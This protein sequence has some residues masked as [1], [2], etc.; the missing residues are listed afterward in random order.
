MEYQALRR[1]VLYYP[2]V[3]RCTALRRDMTTVSRRYMS[4]KGGGRDEKG[5]CSEDKDT[6][7]EL[8]RVPSKIKRAYNGGKVAEG[9]GSH[10][11]SA[12]QQMN[13]SVDNVGTS[14]P[15]MFGSNLHLLV[16]KVASTEYIPIKEV[17]T[18]GLFAGY[19]PLFLGNSSFS[20]DMRKGKN[21]HALD[22]GLPNIQVIDASEKDGKLD[23]QEIIED[24]QKT[25]LIENV[26]DKEQ[27]SSSHKRKPVI[28]WDASISGMVYNDM[29]FKYVPK[30]VISKMKPFK[31]MRIERKS[32][33]KNSK[34]PSM[35]KLQFHNQRINDTQEL[36]NFYQNKTRLHESF[37]SS[38]S[39]QEFKYSSTNMSK[40]QKM[41]K[42]RGDFEH[43]LK[44]Y[45][46]KHTFIKNDQELFR[47]ELTKLNKI[48]SREF[49]KLTKLSI[50]NEF[51]REHLP[52][53]VYVSKSNNTKKLLRRSLKNKI[54]DHIYPVYTTILS[55]LANS[56]DSKKFETKIKGYIEKI[57]TR[58]SDEI[59]STYFFQDGVDCI[60]QPSP[61]HNFK[62][63]HWLRYT[64]RHNTF[65]GRSINKD[66]QVSFN[67]KYVVTR[68]GVKYTRYPTNLNT[69]LLET[70]FEEWDYYE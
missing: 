18:E 62:R 60:I 24:L 46:Y 64:K 1:L 20:S 61:V 52:L 36:V 11:V 27:F 66:V 14:R 51:K 30:N 57:I 28:P 67:D 38:K 70:A 2:K 68:S 43:K 31:L 34:K 40:R 19:R 41:L 63:I 23:V 35:I 29:P 48:L 39:Y 7:K 59:P 49:K 50:H 10:T 53:V 55:T 15:K 3:I 25:S 32:H 5:D 37:Y 16:P 8:G 33:A 42:A 17:H 21:F 26:S 65:W 6:S 47:N 45:A 13:Q 12:L 69:Q 56:K 44:N 54:M 4:G 58:L 9:G 22:D